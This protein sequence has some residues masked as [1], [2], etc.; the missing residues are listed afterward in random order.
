MLIKLLI[1]VCLIA[2]VISLGSG[3]FF[4]VREERDSKR[5]VRALTVRVAL[6]VTLFVLLFL[7]WFLGLIQPNVAPA[8]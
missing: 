2:I 1:I 7:A 5:M 3:L 6:S 4:M 8:G